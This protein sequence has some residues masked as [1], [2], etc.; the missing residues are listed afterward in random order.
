MKICVT[1]APAYSEQGVN[2]QDILA[3]TCVNFTLFRMEEG[4]QI[5]GWMVT[6]II[7]Q[8]FS[9]LLPAFVVEG[10]AKVEKEKL[11]RANDKLL[12][13][14]KERKQLEKFFWRTKRN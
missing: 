3:I 6:F 10:M 12:M 2:R 14:M 9:V 4:A 5:W 13:E 1:P 8:M 11:S 7:Y